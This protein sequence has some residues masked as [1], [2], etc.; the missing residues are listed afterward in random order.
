MKEGEDNKR[1]GAFP[2]GVLAAFYE[3]LGKNKVFTGQKGVARCG[4]FR[5]ARH[6]A[7]GEPPPGNGGL[8]KEEEALMIAERGR[9][10]KRTDQKR[11]EKGRPPRHGARIWRVQSVGF[12]SVG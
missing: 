5:G 11:M 12:A 9:R 3:R 8:E 1:L 6:G 4:H 10:M 7:H 2:L